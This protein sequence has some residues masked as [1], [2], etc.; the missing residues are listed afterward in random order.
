MQDFYDCITVGGGPAGC[1]VAALVAESGFRTLLVER[2]MLPRFHVGESLMPETYDTLQRLGVWQQLQTSG[3]VK[4]YSVQFVASSGRESQPFFFKDHD[5]R[6]RSQT[7]QVERAKFDQ[8]LFENAAAHGADCFDQT[9]VLEPLF[10]A[11]TAVGVRL[12]TADGGRR[13]VRSR[14]LVDATGQQAL[15]AARLGLRVDNPRLHKAAIWT[16]YRGA[17]REP[18]EH[19]GA[20]VI[21]HTRDRAAW[22]WY[23]PLAD[24]VT[25][26]GVVAD[27][28]Y[29][30]KGRGTP[31][32]TFAEELAKCP[33]VQGRVERA[34]R[35]DRHRVAKEFSYS[36]SQ[37]AG[38][39]WVLVGDAWGFIDPV[40][41]S[42]VYF[43]LKT[44]E[45]AA[46]CI[47]EGLR[48]GDTS[49]AQL[50]RWT[51]DFS[52][53]ARWIRKLVEKFY[54]EDFSIGRFMKA[55]PE[56]RANLTDLLIGRV[57]CEGS[58][59]IFDD[60]DPWLEANRKSNRPKVPAS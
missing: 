20:T 28:D 15:L 8:L 5:P 19:G 14:V 16:Y 18:G 36:T 26:V 13:D 9:R 43:A 31:A 11:T 21:L 10:D 44:G 52:A 55:H 49:G 37:H 27:N 53:G 58:G 57:F 7:F 48:R 35:I 38:D 2:E 51:T 46:D 17:H 59:R 29:L 47:V 33:A 6:E 45:M 4:K 34:E 12:Q 23:I 32:E 41:S 40:Y 1:T 60:M 24:D 39:G 54:D 3:F 56:H 30:L 25:S 50:G 22:F 42:G